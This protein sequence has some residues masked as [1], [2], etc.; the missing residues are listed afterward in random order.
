MYRSMKRILKKKAILPA[1]FS[2]EAAYIVPV[3]LLM[4]FAVIGYTIYFH[5]I[6]ISDV[7]AAHLT[8]EGRMAVEYGR[9][10]FEAKIY[11]DGFQD[12]RGLS[13]AELLI[14]G[15]TE[16]Y[17]KGLLGGSLEAK[18]FSLSEEEAETKIKYTLKG[19]LYGDANEGPFMGSVSEKRN[20]Y[21]PQKYS[22][23]TTDIYRV[24]KQCFRQA[25]D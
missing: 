20:I 25:E 2:V 9:I 16:E 1:V 8:E 10:P 11:T 24:A 7:R 21:E 3:I 6:L 5:D 13:E 23:I 18:A 12:K 15:E 17:R 14:S 4:L 22:R 19:F